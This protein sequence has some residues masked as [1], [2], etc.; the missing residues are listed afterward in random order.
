MEKQLSKERKSL[1]LKTSSLTLFGVIFVLVIIA[2]IFNIKG[3]L[4]YEHYIGT[5]S[6]LAIPSILLYFA[7]GVVKPHGSNELQPGERKSIISKTVAC[8]LFAISIVFF[9]VAVVA[10]IKDNLTL[11]E[12]CTG[13]MGSLW[14][15]AF[16]LY[17]QSKTD[18][19][20]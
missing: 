16:S 14:I 11:S 17:L 6:I 1:V 12:N 15:V 2:L 13:I 9:I 20:Q 4:V 10:E 8:I 5:A 19:K 3:D 7:G 18:T